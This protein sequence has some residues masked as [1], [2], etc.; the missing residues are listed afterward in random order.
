MG[1][2]L[3]AIL[4]AGD[5]LAL[6]HIGGSRAYLFR[7]G[8]LTQITRDQ[9]V[10]GPKVD[11]ARLTAAVRARLMR[12]LTGHELPMLKTLDVRAGDRYLLCTHGLSGPVDQETIREALKI[13][14]L[15]NTADR[16]IELALRGGGPDN[17]SVVV[18]DVIRYEP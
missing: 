14:D 5:R 17:I 2:T 9:F 15:P 6:A 13:P 12:R 16:L 7:E 3:T 8:N 11:E 4:F 18:A 1:T 10:T